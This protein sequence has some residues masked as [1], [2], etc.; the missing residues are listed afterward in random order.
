[1]R[2]AHSNSCAPVTFTL[3]LMSELRDS[4]DGELKTRVVPILR[5]SGFKGSYPHF[6]RPRGDALDLLTFQFD[7]YGG[8]FVIELSWCPLDGVTTS[9]GKKIEGSKVTTWD[10]PSD[11]RTRIQPKP[12]GGLDC[13]FRFDNGDVGTPSKQVLA[14]LPKAEKWWSTRAEA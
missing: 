8:G 14:C 11:Q 9:W 12:G 13:W 7:R 5:S 1:M 3:G 10:M 6:R 2:C 4:M